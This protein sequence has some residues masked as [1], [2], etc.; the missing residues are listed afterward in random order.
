MLEENSGSASQVNVEQDV[1][2]DTQESGQQSNDVLNQEKAYSQKQRQRA[3]KAESELEKMT[4][5]NKKIEEDSMVEQNKFKELWEQD[6]DDA[7]WARGYR[8]DRKASLLEKLPED[9]R[10]K[11]QKMNLGLDAL[12]AIVEE[13]NNV[14]PQKET[15]KAVPGGLNTEIQNKDFT[16]MSASEKRDNWSN[17]LEGYK[18]K[19]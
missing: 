9:K 12:E 11:F 3:Q 6:K 7:E 13:I 17:I 14:Q 16:K 4:A 18:N 1:Q 19:T 10:E 15:M 5:R 2:T 8:K